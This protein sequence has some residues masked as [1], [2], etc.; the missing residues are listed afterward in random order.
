MDKICRK[1]QKIK[2]VNEFCPDKRIKSGYSTLCKKCDSERCEEYRKKNRETCDKS[3]KEWVERKLKKNPNFHKERYQKNKEKTAEYKKINAEKYR[4]QTRARCKIS[5]DIF[6]GKLKRP[7]I[8]E[9]CLGR[10]SKI[11]AHHEDYSKPREI[12]WLCIKCHKKADKEKRE[13][14]DSNTILSRI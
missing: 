3:K 5:L 14:N 9:S 8:C 10:F 7:D 12:I 2:E 11:E 4:I 13:R 1:C 6:C